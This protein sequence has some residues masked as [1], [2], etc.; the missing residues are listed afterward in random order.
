MQKLAII[1]AV[2]HHPDLLIMDEPAGALD[3]VQRRTF[4][5]FILELV[6]SEI[7]SVLISSHDLTDVEKI[8][9][10]VVCLHQGRVR[11]DASFDEI[12]ER[13][14]TWRVV[15]PDGTLPERF[16]EPYI[17]EVE[18]NRHGAIMQ[19]LDGDEADFSARHGVKIQH[20][21]MNLEK[22]F[23]LWLGDRQ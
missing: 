4:L 10:H 1:L 19:V 17:L 13:Y 6:Q 22:I 23:P 9:D 20:I 7:Q 2:G 15:S 8:I 3:P 12:R 11:I 5:A 21:P 14:A 18:G 16:W